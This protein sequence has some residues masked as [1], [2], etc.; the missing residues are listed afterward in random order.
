MYALKWKYPYH[1][2]VELFF[3]IKKYFAFFVKNNKKGKRN[4]ALTF[5]ILALNYPIFSFNFRLI[6]RVE[7]YTVTQTVAYTAT[8]IA[9]NIATMLQRNGNQ[10]LIK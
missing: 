7:R 6:L 10:R 5:L 2:R 9:V 8:K 1:V 4:T 3:D